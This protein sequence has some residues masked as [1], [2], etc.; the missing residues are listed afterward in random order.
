V[1]TEAGEELYGRVKEMNSILSIGIGVINESRSA[2][3]GSLRLT[4]TV[5]FGSAW[6]TPRMSAFRA[7]FPEIT[8]SLLLTDTSRLDLLMRQADCAIRFSKQTEP[9]LIQ[10]HLMS[11]TYK[12]FGC[13]E[14]FAEHGRPETVEDLDKHQIIVYGED[15]PLPDHDMNWLLTVGKP[16]GEHREPA[17]SVNNVYGIYR[18]V[19]SGLGIAALPPYLTERSSNLVHILPQYSGPTFEVYFV[20]PEELRR[21]RRIAAVRDFLLEQ[22]EQWKH[23]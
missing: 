22:I 20:Y 1:L 17:L 16:A 8:M 18:A 15:M 3:T 2:P 11:V 13:Q 23:E 5:G 10:R 4:T 21:S 14:Y 7:K 12:V 19:E 6:L 9:T